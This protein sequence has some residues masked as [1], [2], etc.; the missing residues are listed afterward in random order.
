[1]IGLSFVSSNK[2]FSINITRKSNSS[3]YAQ[4]T[5]PYPPIPCSYPCQL[6]HKW[7]SWFSQ[8]TN[9]PLQ[10]KKTFLGT[11]IIKFLTHQK[12]H[13]YYSQYQ[14]TWKIAYRMFSPFSI[15][16][17]ATTLIIST[18]PCL[19]VLYISVFQLM[20]PLCVDIA[21]LA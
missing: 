20:P 17:H 6:Q 21:D 10:N 12:F 16:K 5:Y 1:M 14:N 11:R 4:S 2:I 13:S 8:E 18:Q 9:R 3:Q 7:Q 15:G 19:S